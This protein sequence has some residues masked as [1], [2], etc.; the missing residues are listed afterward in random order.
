MA[1]RG[2]QRQSDIE[3]LVAWMDGQL[4]GPEA[5]RVA[6]LVRTEPAWQE[7]YRQF[8]AVDRAM[9]FVAVPQPGGDLTDRIVRAAHR[10]PAVLRLVRVLAP[11]AAAAVIVL[12]IGLGKFVGTA[13]PPVHGGERAVAKFIDRQLQDI[14]E[15]DRFL[16][17]NLSMF[18]NY[19]EVVSYR[20]VR[21][22]IDGETLSALAEM[23]HD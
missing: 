8:Q 16:V 9:D 11:L 19:R 18:Q 6:A 1:V 13:S 17:A 7:T 21:P 5:D 14:P 23:E 3:D 2:L 4:A 12:G 20:Q 10:G 15:G 22:I